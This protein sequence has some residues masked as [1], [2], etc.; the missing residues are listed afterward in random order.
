MALVYK[1]LK[2]FSHRWNVQVNV[3]SD[4]IRYYPSHFLG[5]DE[6]WH[7]SQDNQALKNMCATLLL[8]LNSLNS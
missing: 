7:P 2:L 5:A 3:N 8:G 4:L 6:V 1:V